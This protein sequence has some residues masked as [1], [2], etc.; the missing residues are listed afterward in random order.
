MGVDVGTGS[1]RAGLFSIDGKLLGKASLLIE[2]NRPKPDFVEQS[3]RNIWMAVCKATRQ[4]LSDSNTDASA[5]KGIGF[6]ATYSTVALDKSLFPLSISPNGNCF[7]NVIVWMD[8]RAKKQASTINST[9]HQEL[10]RLGGKINPEMP[11][12]KMLWVKENMPEVWQQRGCFMMLH[13]WLV[14]HA[15]FADQAPEKTGIS[16]ENTDSANNFLQTI[17]LEDMTDELL[18]SGPQTDSSPRRGELTIKAAEELGLMA[19]TPVGPALIDACAGAIGMISAKR[20]G[21]EVNYN[22]RIALTSGTSNCYMTASDQPRNVPGIWGP[23]KSILVPDMWSNAAG[24]STG[25][26]LT[27]HIIFTHPASNELNKMAEGKSLSVYQQLNETLGSIAGSPEAIPFLAKDIHVLP[28]FL[29]NR[30]PRANPDLTGMVTGLTLTTSLESLALLY[31]ATIQAI[32]MG[33]THIIATMNQ[34]GYKINSIL[35]C[36]GGSK[37]TLFLQT[38]A[39]VTGCHVYLPTVPESVLLGGAMVG[40]VAA[41]EFDG[42]LG[43]AMSSMNTIGEVVLPEQA[44]VAFYNAKYKVFLELYEDQEKYRRMMG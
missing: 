13:E 44:S 3:T 38:L 34:G 21:K 7:W 11:V 4:V 28:Y 18:R 23:A 20:N 36:G 32:A 25:G 15:T 39:N 14:W 35:A 33:G 2:I 31:L 19:G 42:K 41:G 24:Q 8:H 17:G 1:V 5:V 12:P 6:D 22:Q 43:T 16:L 29:G 37:N 30:N 26:S 27:D 10:Q 40:A 9:Q